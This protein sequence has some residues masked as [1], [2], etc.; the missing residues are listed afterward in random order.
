MH[1][2]C[3]QIYISDGN[4]VLLLSLSSF[5]CGALGLSGRFNELAADELADEETSSASSCNDSLVR[6]SVHVGANHIPASPT[7]GCLC[8]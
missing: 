4:A 5:L 6:E 3:V 7:Q 8:L 2:S 1:P